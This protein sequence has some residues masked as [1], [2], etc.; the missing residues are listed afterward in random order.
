MSEN[1]KRSRESGVLNFP[2]SY[3]ERFTPQ[4]ESA[5]PMRCLNCDGEYTEDRISYGTKPK[6]GLM[7]EPLWWCPTPECNGAG[8]GIDIHVVG[9]GD[10]QK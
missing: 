7:P 1:F 3:D 9:E 2:P 4:R 10:K 6:V 5:R 8:L